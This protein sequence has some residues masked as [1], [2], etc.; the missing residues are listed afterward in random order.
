MLGGKPR[1]NRF[2][3]GMNS[4]CM[5]CGTVVDH[6]P[7]EKKYRWL[8][9][10]LAVILMF[11]LGFWLGRRLAPPTAP[12]CPSA[13]NGAPLG[14]GVGEGG[15]GSPTKRSGGPGGGG[16]GGTSTGDGE[17]QAAGGGSGGGGGGDGSL[18]GGGGPG[19]ALPT[20]GGVGGGGNA[21]SH[22]GPGTGGGLDGDA[23]HAAGGGRDNHFDT[24]SVTDAA[25]SDS[26]GDMVA[27]VTKMSK[28]G[29][30]G[31]G[32]AK[33][34][35]APE[36]PRG[37]NLSA[38]DL[39]YDRTGLP[40]YT[41]HITGL[42]SSVSYPDK[43]HQETYGTSAAVGTTDSFDTVVAWYQQN[44]PPGWSSSALG[45]LQRLG[46][47]AQMLNPGNLLKMLNGR[48]GATAATEVPETATA[49]R[50]RLAILK[51]PPNTPGEPGIIIMQK[52]DKPVLA[53]NK[54]RFP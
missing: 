23:A 36:D 20:D 30:L 12:P 8:W 52:G 38:K 1:W 53:F 14:G 26:D 54:R 15:K 45:D 4:Y 2:L 37:Q 43:T 34:D 22:A 9:W 32:D 13:G 5:Q 50:I 31:V 44:L 42:A 17:V 33:D 18:G 7:Q 28:G 35:S 46:A 16:G 24:G 21:S 11:A 10:L 3:C 41:S 25:G 6:P 27:G 39:R 40:H 47:Q 51:P 49:D 19:G 48:Q 29:Q